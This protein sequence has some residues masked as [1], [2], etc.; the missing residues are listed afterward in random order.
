[1]NQRHQLTILMCA[2][3]Q[4]ACGG[5]GGGGSS[6]GSVAP[7]SADASVVGTVPGT[8]IEAFGDN[9]SYHV[10]ESNDNGTSRHPF[11]HRQRYRRQ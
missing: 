6:T 1:M 8:M 3:L 11:Q 9:G 7:S 2:L 5:G 10:V 4:A